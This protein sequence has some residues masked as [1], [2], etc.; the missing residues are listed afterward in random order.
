MQSFL[1]TV[2]TLLASPIINRLLAANFY[3]HLL[4]Y[5]PYRSNGVACLL[6]DQ[7]I[8]LQE[9]IS[10]DDLRGWREALSATLALVNSRNEFSGLDAATTA[11]NLDILK[12]RVRECLQLCL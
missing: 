4:Y 7:G 1:H 5:L 12:L 6:I 3:R 11:A 10:A 9:A 2:R 8:R